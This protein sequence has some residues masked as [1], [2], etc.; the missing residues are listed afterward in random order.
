LLDARLTM[1]FAMVPSVI[2]SRESLV[3]DLTT[4]GFDKDTAD[5]AVATVSDFD[6][7]K[8]QI[9]LVRKQND[10]FKADVNELRALLEETILQNNKTERTRRRSTLQKNRS[11]TDVLAAVREQGQEEI[12]T[13]RALS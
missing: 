6:K 5:T 12:N 7:L 8:L 13:M 3:K 9:D 11:A 1:G 10:G 4:Y 2:I